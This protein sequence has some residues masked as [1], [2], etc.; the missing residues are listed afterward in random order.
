MITVS[1]PN[2]LNLATAT[3]TQNGVP[4]ALAGYLTAAGP[5]VWQWVIPANAAGFLPAG[6]QRLRFS[7][8]ETGVPVGRA[9]V[10]GVNEV[11]Y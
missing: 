7:V 8:T 9:P 4:F 2:G 6:P 5:L 11:Q 1:S 10:P 3:L